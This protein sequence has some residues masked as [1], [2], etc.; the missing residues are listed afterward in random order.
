MDDE[1][2]AVEVTQWKAGRVLSDHDVWLIGE[3][4]RQ[5]SD[6][7]GGEENAFSAGYEQ[8]M[9]ECDRAEVPELIKERDAAKGMLAFYKALATVSERQV[10]E[11][12]AR[13]ATGAR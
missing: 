4:L 3:L 1:I 13:I 8:A 11:L 6:E 7:I 12:K 5:H 2:P 10:H 9:S